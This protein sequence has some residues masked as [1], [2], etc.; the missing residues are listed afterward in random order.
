[1]RHSAVPIARAPKPNHSTV[2]T[3]KIA[4]PCAIFSFLEMP[5]SK[6]VS[7]ISR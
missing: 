4:L 1:M 5:C 3:E 7:G 6:P 2:S